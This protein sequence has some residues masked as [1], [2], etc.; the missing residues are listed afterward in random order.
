MLEL[1]DDKIIRHP[2]C[3][4]P[5]EQHY[6][7]CDDLLDDIKRYENSRAYFYKEHPEFKPPKGK[8]EVVKDCN[9]KGF[10]LLPTFKDYGVLY[11]GQG[12]YYPKCLPTLYRNQ[13]TEE[14]LFA[15]QVKIAEFKLCL[16]QYDITKR[17]ENANYNV[18]YIGLAQ[19]YGLN[20][21]VLDLTSDVE[22]ALF[23]AMCDKDGD[24]YKPKTENKEYIGYLYA[25]P[26]NEGFR[27]SNDV[28]ET[29]SDRIKV[30][31]LQPF[32]RPGLQKGYAYHVGKEGLNYG[33]L[34]SFNYTKNESERFYNK[35]E[36]GKALW[37]DDHITQYAENIKETKVLSHQAIVLASRMFGHTISTKKRCNQL[38]KL[39]Y[40][41]VSYR[42]HSWFGVNL[43]C[44]DAQWLNIQKDIVSRSIITENKKYPCINT[45]FIGEE[46]TFNYIYGCTDCPEGYDSGFSYEEYIN[47]PKYGLC[48]D[49]AHKP[50][51]PD[52]A[53]KKIHAA[54]KG[55]NPNA[56]T[57]RSFSL[58]DYFKSKLKKM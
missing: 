25:I 39:G 30:I 45:K 35:F 15:E 22:I 43:P 11:R 6:K 13:L 44:D 56:P 8:F 49:S 4:V 46:L 29:F 47:A 50:L 9:G 26:A 17:F 27:N 14:E 3:I 12:N 33:Y 5:P 23:F 31:G 48:V 36:Q 32:K 24:C 34:Y 54:W 21:G 38:K 28:F 7:S 42:K 16:S 19:H 20:T 58:P 53:D 18:D 40:R 2:I 57:V 41:I 1:T 51:V 52:E 55:I 37:C 10:I